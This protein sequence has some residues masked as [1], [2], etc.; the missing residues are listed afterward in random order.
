MTNSYETTYFADD[1]TLE[2][3]L[4]WRLTDIFGAKVDVESAS[5]K[6][7]LNCLVEF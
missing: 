7:D 4:L 1:I 6:F 5:V 2:V 3:Y